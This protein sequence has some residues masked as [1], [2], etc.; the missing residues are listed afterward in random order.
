MRKSGTGQFL[1]GA[2]GCNAESAGWRASTQTGVISKGLWAQVSTSPSLTVARR[3]QFSVVW[4]FCVWTP[5]LWKESNVKCQM[6]LCC[7]VLRYKRLKRMHVLSNY[8]NCYEAS[9]TDQVLVKHTL[10]SESVAD[11]SHRSAHIS[12]ELYYTLCL[13]TISAVKRN[14]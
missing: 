13:Y 4:S 1:R 14:K 6:Q 7:I 12:C 3:H 5:D 8:I 9:A 11:F 10:R 2:P